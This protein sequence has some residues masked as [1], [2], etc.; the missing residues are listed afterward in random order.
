MSP[1]IPKQLLK[2]LE[3]CRVVY[4]CK[5]IERQDLASKSNNLISGKVYGQRRGRWGIQLFV[6]DQAR[7]KPLISPAEAQR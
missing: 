5:V 6:R 2:G 1:S 3:Y 4:V 7:P